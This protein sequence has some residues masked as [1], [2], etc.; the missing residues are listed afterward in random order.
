MKKVKI[1][2]LLISLAAFFFAMTGCA[3]AEEKAIG[4]ASG[5]E[6]LA[7][8]MAEYMQ[9]ENYEA[10]YSAAL[11]IIE[12]DPENAAGYTGASSALLEMSKENYVQ[13]NDLLVQASTNATDTDEV[14]RWIDENDTALKITMP[15]ITDYNSEEEINTVGN[16]G[17]NIMNIGYV[18]SQGQWIY[19]R[20]NDDDGA[21]YKMR[22]DKT[23]ARK[24]S[25]DVPK[26]INVIG[27]W[28]YYVCENEDNALYKIR[29][30]G[31]ERAKITNDGCEYVSYADGWLYYGNLSDEICLY[32]IRTD[33]S[34]R[35][36]LVKKMTKCPYVVGDW[37]YYTSKQ[38]GGCLYKVS[39]DGKQNKKVSGQYMYV[40]AIYSD[41]VYYWRGDSAEMI[42][43]RVGIDGGNP[44]AVYDANGKKISGF[45]VIDDRLYVLAGDKIVIV[46]TATFKEEKTIDNTSEFIFT[47]DGTK[48]YFWEWYDDNSLY[49]MNADGSGVEKTQ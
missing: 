21:L 33:G 19:F 13:I 32:K 18:A 23:G 4:R 25:N 26:F 1:A 15:F 9:E 38:D 34:G 22:S 35:T 5:T 10:A 30:D 48:V 39:T 24:L 49:V 7:A 6:E 17:S 31:K 28:I 11:K 41:Y 47:T 46:N 20:N 45:N 3:S 12:T 36:R 14:S 2:L 43:Y 44:E 16:S 42:I 27:D 37:V 8:L 29:T 40:F